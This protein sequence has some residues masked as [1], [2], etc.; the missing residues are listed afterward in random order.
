MG[1]PCN[2]ALRASGPSF[3]S[4][5]SW[6]RRASATSLASTASCSTTSSSSTN[7][8]GTPLALEHLQRLEP[9]SRAAPARVVGGVGEALDLVEHEA[10]HHEIAPP[11][12]AG[13]REREQLA[14]HQHRGVDEQPVA[15]VEG[16]A[17][18]SGRVDM[19]SV[20]STATL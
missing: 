14:V 20:S 3:V 6:S 12:P 17:R 8:R 10:G 19:P 4:S 13:A 18:T 2:S 1:T 9:A 11:T 15:R 7:T 16:V 5:R